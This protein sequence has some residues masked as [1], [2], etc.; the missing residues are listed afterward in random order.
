MGGLGKGHLIRE[1]DAMGGVIGLNPDR[2]IRW[3]LNEPEEAVQVEAQI[4]RDLYK[5]N[6]QR[7]VRNSGVELVEGEVRDIITERKSGNEII[8]GVETSSVGK[9]YCKKLVVTTGTFLS[10]VIYRGKEKWKA[11]RLNARPSFDLAKFFKS[12][13]YQTYRLKTGTPPRLKGVQ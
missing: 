8:I 4:D 3:M 2:S 9:L 13:K 12:E 11:G 5:E 6:I 10:G 7:I 1:I